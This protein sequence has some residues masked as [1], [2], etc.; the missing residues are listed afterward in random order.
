MSTK[1]KFIGFLFFSILLLDQGSKIVVDRTV[2]LHHS[3]SVI[4]NLFNLIHIRN[5]GAAFGILAGTQGNIGVYVLILFSL[6]AAGFIV[7][8]LRR[9]PST[10]KALIT[11]LTFILSGAVGNL[12]DRLLYG[13]VIDFLD[14]Y[15]SSHHWPAFNVADSFISIGVTLSVLRLIMAKGED[16]FYQ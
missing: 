9:L 7:T 3:I 1:G 8:L 2:P 6:L 13:E 12:I 10:E 15:W 16:P 4:Q 14:F 11:G 5:T